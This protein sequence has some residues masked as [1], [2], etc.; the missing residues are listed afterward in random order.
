MLISV[1]LE[2]PSFHFFVYYISTLFLVEWCEQKTNSDRFYGN[3][4][5]RTDNFQE[6]LVFTINV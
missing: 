2:G 6:N 4:V 3:R 1:S 5:Q